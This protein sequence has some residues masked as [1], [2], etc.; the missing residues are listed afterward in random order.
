GSRLE[1]LA[2]QR[3]V[4]MVA[5]LA[6]DGALADRGCQC[7]PLV[8]GLRAVGNAYALLQL[9]R[10][11]LGKAAARAGEAG[12]AGKPVG[13]DLAVQVQELHQLMDAIVH[14]RTPWRRP[15]SALRTK[16]VIANAVMDSASRMIY[17]PACSVG[18]HAQTSATVG[19]P[20]GSA[21]RP[22][23]RRGATPRRDAAGRARGSRPAAATGSR[24]F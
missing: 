20:Q 5:L 15:K 14:R 1:E 4:A 24:A 9:L 6:G 18:G 7:A 11:P 3:R 17:V 2:D 21:I 8:Y 23:G 16:T 13:R 22:G 12:I 10:D 19:W